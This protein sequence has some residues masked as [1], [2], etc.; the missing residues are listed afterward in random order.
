MEIS[1]RS[2]VHPTNN[3]MPAML[4][5]LTS[6]EF[7]VQYLCVCDLAVQAMASCLNQLL[8]QNQGFEKHLTLLSAS[9]MK[10][11]VFCDIQDR[12]G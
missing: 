5:P 9:E 1:K 6:S 11:R 4:L 12:A 3:G 10:S 7:I 2:P 8:K